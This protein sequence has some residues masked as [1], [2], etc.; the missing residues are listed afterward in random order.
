MNKVIEF[1]RDEEGATAIE[2]ALIVAVIAL[3]M[4]VGA[5][6]LGTTLSKFFSST[7]GGKLSTVAAS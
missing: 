2:Y 4:Y 6:V 5:A 7:I 1:I 3:V